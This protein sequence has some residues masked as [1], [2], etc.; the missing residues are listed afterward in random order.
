[1]KRTYSLFLSTTLLLLT[2]TGWKL[3]AQPEWTKD[4]LDI[5]V[6]IS[7]AP[8]YAFSDYTYGA[9]YFYNEVEHLTHL[10][11]GNIRSKTYGF[12]SVDAAYRLGKRWAV[13]L[14]AGYSR[15]DAD[16]YDPAT[17]E[18]LRSEGDNFFSLMAGGRFYWKETPAVRFYSSLYMGL[19][20]HNRNL[21]Y[22]NAS[23][24]DK[25]LFGFQITFAGFQF[26]RKTYC[27][28]E[29]GD[30]DLSMGIPLGIRLGVGYRF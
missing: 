16:F 20:L 19:M 22:W 11:T 12:Y 13:M 17:K 25:D 14:N 2:L 9:E 30:G 24:Y 5:N 15:M 26:G 23:N 6:A 21:D 29:L 3:S 18:F 8:L 27:V 28:V 1:M 7:G 10:Y 4:R